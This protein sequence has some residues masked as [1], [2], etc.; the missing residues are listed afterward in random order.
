[1]GVSVDGLS[2]I[3]RR[4]AERFSGLT[5]ILQRRSLETR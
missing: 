1:M 2:P 5:L 3:A 4:G